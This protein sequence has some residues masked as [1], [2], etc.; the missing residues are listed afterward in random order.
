MY[1][2]APKT[3]SLGSW[4]NYIVHSS[5]WGGHG[6]AVYDSFDFEAVA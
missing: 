4:D 3:A 1:G 5:Q 2:R 6:V